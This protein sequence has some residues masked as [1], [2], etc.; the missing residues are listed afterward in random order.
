MN[1]LSGPGGM[2]GYS[3]MMDAQLMS[4]RAAQD[5]RQAQLDP[6]S[7]LRVAQESGAHADTRLDARGVQGLGENLNRMV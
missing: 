5:G 4:Q 1:A 6:Q 7:Q 2:G 3:Q